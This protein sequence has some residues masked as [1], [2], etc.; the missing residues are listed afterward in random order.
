MEKLIS[1]DLKAPMG[2]L[3]KPDI[4]EGIYLTF[5]MLHKPGLLGILGAI[6]GL[7]GYQNKGELPEYY[8]WLKDLKIGIQPLDYD[9]KHKNSRGNFQKTT[10]KYNNTVGYANADG[11]TLNIVE[12]TLIKLNYRCFL[13]F[14]FGLALHRMM[15]D[16][17]KKYEAEFLPYLG[18]NEYSLWWQAYREYDYESFR[19]NR[20][21]KVA[22][23]FRKAEQLVKEM[24]ESSGGAPFLFDTSSSEPEFLYFEELPV[25]FDEELMQYQRETFAY[26]NF[27]FRKEKELDGLYHLKEENAIIQLF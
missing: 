23:I 24:R 22:T 3:K 14:D 10:I 1:I 8:P 11:G 25:G 19:F 27:T 5:N 13:L 26:T 15:D 17:L 20:N 21:Y 9:A 2:F 4:N 16:Y 12:Q 7:K 6:A 18:K